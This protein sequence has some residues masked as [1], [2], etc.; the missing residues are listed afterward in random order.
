MT[1]LQKISILSALTLTLAFSSCGDTA[2]NSTES[3]TSVETSTTTTAPTDDTEVE[4]TTTTTAAVEEESAAESEE[5]KGEEIVE[6]DKGPVLKQVIHHKNSVES[7]ITRIE[8]FDSH[9]NIVS[10]VSYSNDN[11]GEQQVL[12][13]Y[14]YENDKI[15]TEI[16]DNGYSISKDTYDYLPDGRISTIKMEIDDGAVYTIYEYNDDE[17]CIVEKMYYS[18][19]FSQPAKK[20]ITTISDENGNK[21]EQTSYSANDDYTSTCYWNYEYDNNNNIV[22]EYFYGSYDENIQKITEYEYDEN[23]NVTQEKTYV[24]SSGVPSPDEISKS[25]YPDTDYNDTIEYKNQS[26]I[27]VSL[28]IYENIYYD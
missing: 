25:I 14:E 8:E 6:D 24:I 1:N 22:K 18:D 7:P 20:I 16:V 2:H 4:T 13:T 3:K 19:D 12:Y 26:Y 28:Y 11:A 27:R 9:G 17:N 23:N 5:V 21:I 10:L 15:K